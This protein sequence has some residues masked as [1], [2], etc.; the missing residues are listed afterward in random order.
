MPGHR[1]G[2]PG[3]PTREA[4]EHP[5]DLVALLTEVASSD[6]DFQYMVTVAWLHDIIEDGRTEAGKPVTAEDLH[7]EGFAGSVIAD[8][9]LLT[10]T[11]GT[12]KSDYFDR[13]AYQSNRRVQIVKVV[14]RICNLRDGRDVFKDARWKRYIEETFEHV[15]H[16]TLEVEPA[17]LTRKLDDLLEEAIAARGIYPEV[18]DE[19]IV[20]V[21]KTE[22]RDLL[23]IAKKDPE[24]IQRGWPEIF[25]AAGKVTP[26]AAYE[27][28]LSH[29]RANRYPR[30]YCMLCGG[31]AREC[32]PRHAQHRSCA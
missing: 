15:R 20:E 31:P 5:Q 22:S 2:A 4:W 24:H 16:L 25:D 8:V 19:M 32:A 28:V 18:P 9:E 13:I 14:D 27:K 23:E 1:Q 12:P 29:L 17:D 6:A 11:P 21:A 26:T 7:N 30:G 10:H 3:R